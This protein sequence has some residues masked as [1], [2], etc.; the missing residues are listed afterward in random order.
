MHFD[1]FFIITPINLSC[2]IFTLPTSAY[3]T[4]PNFQYRIADI[5]IRSTSGKFT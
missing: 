2:Y 3:N 4:E 1:C 5:Y